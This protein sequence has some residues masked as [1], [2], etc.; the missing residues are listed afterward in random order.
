MEYGI[1]LQCL[2]ELAT[3]SSSGSLSNS[4]IILSERYIY[5]YFLSRH[6]HVTGI[7]GH[8]S[9]TPSLKHEQVDPN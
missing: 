9:H 3:E 7:S 4:D 6:S 1:L 8:S 5:A 2:H